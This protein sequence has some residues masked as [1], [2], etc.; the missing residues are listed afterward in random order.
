MKTAQ[1]LNEWLQNHQKER[2]KVSTY[3]KYRLLINLHIVPALGDCDIS[4]ITRRQ[5][6]EFL[7]HEKQCG[8]QRFSGTLSAT[9]VNLMLSILNMAFEYA[10]DLEIAQS[11]PCERIKRTP[12]TACDEGKA[13]TKEEQ[14][15]LEQTIEADGGACLFGIILCLYTGL[16]IGEL[17]SLE[18]TDLNETFT[19]LSVDKTVCRGKDEENQWQ[20]YVDRPKTRSSKRK[21]PLPNHITKKLKELKKMTFST[22]IIANKKGERMSTRSYQYM[23]EKLTEKA[24]IRKL[25]FHALRH[26]FATRAMENGIDIKTLSEIMGH[27]NASIT[28]NRY[29]H[30]MA[31]TKIQMMNKMERI[32]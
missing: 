19:V 20:V 22:Y 12:N 21:I 30:S 17:L 7:Q 32:L 5:I 23:F 28:L 26:T 14:R 2:T 9:S 3:D 15:K 27:Q 25:N 18:W 11:N 29:A 6:Y 1:L 13:F 24:G 10:C 4:T 8:N 31:E 16:R